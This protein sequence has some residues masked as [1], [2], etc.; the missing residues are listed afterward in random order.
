MPQAS[1]ASVISGFSTGEADGARASVGEGIGG[2]GSG[3]FEGGALGPQGE[4]RGSAASAAGR[5]AAAATV[6]QILHAT[7]GRSRDSTPTPSCCGHSGRGDRPPPPLSE[8][9]RLSDT[10]MHRSLG[11][12][13][14]PFS[15]ED[16]ARRP[17]ASAAGFGSVPTGGGRS[18]AQGHVIE[19]PLVGLLALPTAPRRRLCCGR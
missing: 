17:A 7:H 6:S 16:G 1:L 15:G 4:R 5:G 14:W 9:A 11:P 19:P 18:T 13:A 3:A 12:H 8:V 2:G 10:L